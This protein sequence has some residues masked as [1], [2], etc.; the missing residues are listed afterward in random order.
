MA[1]RQRG[2]GLAILAMV[3]MLSASGAAGASASNHSES[4]LSLIVA[5]S[6]PANGLHYSDANDLT[7]SVSVYNEGDND[8]AFEH[9]PSCPFTMIITNSTGAIVHD[10]DDERNCAGQWRAIDVPAGGEQH[11]STLDWSWTATVP[12]GDLLIAIDSGDEIEAETFEV[13]YHRE[14]AMP[15][16]LAFELLMPPMPGGRMTSEPGEPVVAR[17]TLSNHG[18]EEIEVPF[19]D[20][21]RI[22]QSL[23]IA[24]ISNI[25]C[26]GG[27]KISPGASIDLGWM[28][29]SPS[30]LGLADG[31]YTISAWPAGA[32]G[33]AWSVE[34]IHEAVESDQR[35]EGLRLSVARDNGNSAVAS[36][37]ELTLVVDLHNDDDIARVASFEDDC[38]VRLHIV[39]ADGGL[40]YD[41]EGA[42]N[43]VPALMEHKIQPDESLRLARI[44]L[45]TSG[46]DGC[47]WAGGDHL[48]IVRSPGIDLYEIIEFE[49][50]DSDAERLC[51]LEAQSLEQTL[52][53]V[54]EIDVIDPDGDNESVLFGL[55][56]LHLDAEPL[57]IQWP[58]DCRISFHLSTVDG[59]SATVSEEDCDGIAGDSTT[60]LSGE[61]M[62]LGPFEHAF[63]I[64]GVA[65]PTSTYLIE[66]RTQSHPSLTT[67]LIHAYDGI[68]QE[69]VVEEEEE[70][71]II[72][73][74]EPVINAPNPVVLEGE[75]IHVRTDQGGCWL[76]RTVAGDE[77]A[78]LASTVTG[79]SPSPRL[80]G[81]YRV[82]DASF[83]AGDACAVWSPGLKVVSVIDE[84][85]AP[86]PAATSPNQEA[87]STDENI[88][89]TVVA[90]APPAVMIVV[91][92]SMIAMLLVSIVNTEWI[93]LPAMNLGLALVGM[94]RRNRDYDGEF[95]RGRI[96]G[97]LVANPGAHFRALLGAL[98]M[99]NGQLAHHLKVLEAEEKLWRR[100][101]GRL[102]RFYPA[103]VRKMDEDDLPVPLLTPDPN[104]LQGKILTLLDQTGNEYINL[105]QR[106]LAERLEASQQLI[107]HHLRTLEKYGLVEREKVGLRYRYEL[108]R[109]ATFLLNSSDW[110][111]P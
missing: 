72:V 49:V 24:S 9:N 63:A 69:P 102:V 62:L 99:S 68:A 19:D 12:S 41:E 85:T 27:E 2:P 3:L 59:E 83:V 89:A 23:S 109:E 97:F 74:D 42:T 46:F 18:S 7:I 20:A 35:V 96:I 47:G 40:P 22:V 54:V 65:L 108:T 110:P 100:R 30:D 38:W 73:V 106:E 29:W 34:W 15:D 94:V 91:T 56:L 61:S 5:I 57:V 31:S 107:S 45:E 104:S 55:R 90:V 60:L 88:A 92:T 4:E 81:A 86:E 79:W 11:I 10:L 98:S 6:A 43:C 33:D 52:F 80:Q 70:Q 14:T 13:T 32:A 67:A 103:T 37:E 39:S 111:S 1:L 66:A 76:L 93:R 50:E 84:W 16:D 87:A 58:S 71:V 44:T 64:D 21:C 26:G 48:A 28:T 95:Q 82:A 105:S 17:A 53:E 25:G 8:H 75:W 78:L 36:G 77:R 101:D 51:R